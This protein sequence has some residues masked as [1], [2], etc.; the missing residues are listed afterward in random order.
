MSSETPRTLTES[1]LYRIEG[2]T[3]IRVPPLCR[4]T[5]VSQIANSGGRFAYASG[6]FLNIFPPFFFLPL[7]CLV[8]HWRT[9]VRET[10]V[11]RTHYREETFRGDGPFFYCVRK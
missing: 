5:P 2:L 8:A 4:E 10:D 1:T 3:S 6:V 11:S 7:R 9:A